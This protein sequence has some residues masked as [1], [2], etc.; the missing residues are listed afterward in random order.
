MIATD[1]LCYPFASYHVLQDVVKCTVDH[2][3]ASP[4][5]G[6]LVL[7]LRLLLPLLHVVKCRVAAVVQPSQHRPLFSKWSVWT[8]T[9]YAAD[10][11]L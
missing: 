9:P 3:R 4:P 2:L 1:S 6:W 5:P 8:N 7:M 11:C 10:K